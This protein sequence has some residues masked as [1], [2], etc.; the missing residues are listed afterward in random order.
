[1]DVKGGSARPA[2]IGLGNEFIHA[3]HMNKG[4]R[5]GASTGKL[6]PEV[7]NNPRVLEFEETNTRE[8]ESRLRCEHN[9]TPRILP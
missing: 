2:F 1:M 5:N 9:I 4:Q 3:R 7:K 8:E 6:D